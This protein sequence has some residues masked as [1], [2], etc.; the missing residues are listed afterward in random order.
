MGKN[1]KLHHHSVREYQS[2]RFFLGEGQ[3]GIDGQKKYFMKGARIMSKVFKKSYVM[4]ALICMLVAC[5]TC[6]TLVLTANAQEAE[7]TSTVTF[8]SYTTVMR[9]EEEFEFAALVTNVGLPN[10]WR[11]IP[12]NLRQRFD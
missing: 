2:L 3:P 12:E 4:T 5:L 8:T 6:G 1:K 9:V 7:P 10:F 11:E